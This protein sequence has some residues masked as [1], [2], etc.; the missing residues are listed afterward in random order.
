MG[1]GGLLWYLLVGWVVDLGI[2]DRGTYRHFVDMWFWFEEG[3]VVSMKREENEKE[4][5]SRVI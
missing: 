2:F 3:E 1:A 5:G 4:R